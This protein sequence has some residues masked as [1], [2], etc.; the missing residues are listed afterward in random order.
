MEKKSPYIFNARAAGTWGA[1]K[2]VKGTAGRFDIIMDQ[3]E[4]I[5]GTDLGPSP[6][7]IVT[8]ALVGCAGITFGVIAKQMDFSFSGIELEAD[9]DV[10]IRGFM[11]QPGVCRHF[12]NFRGTF[13]VETEESEERLQEVAAQVENRCP[14][15]CL[16]Q[17]AGVKMEIEWKKK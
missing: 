1:P 8:A 14:V 17:D 9:G 3:P 11:G 2:M 15:F 7:E 16:L 10:D 4:S 5:G 13:V 12:C 6:L